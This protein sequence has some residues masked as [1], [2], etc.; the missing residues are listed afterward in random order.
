VSV[1]GLFVGGGSAVGH[2]VIELSDVGFTQALTDSSYVCEENA[3]LSGESNLM[4]TCLS[5]NHTDNITGLVFKL[6]TKHNF[7]V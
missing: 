7:T 6:L 4:K 5:L 2:R 1:H 3:F